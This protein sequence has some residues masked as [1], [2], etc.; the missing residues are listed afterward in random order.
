M[1]ILVFKEE[2]EVAKTETE[3][4]KKSDPN[5]D[6]ETVKNAKHVIEYNISSH[7]LDDILDSKFKLH[8]LVG[9]CSNA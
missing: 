6:E 3:E 7:S 8:F 5:G 9:T 4:K 2:D 1:C